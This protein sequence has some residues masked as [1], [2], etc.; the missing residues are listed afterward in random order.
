M[1]TQSGY[2]S[3][4]ANDPDD[5]QQ[6]QQGEQQPPTL[7]NRIKQF[8]YETYARKH[9]LPVV[10]LSAIV[11]FILLLVGLATWL[12]DVKHKN[13]AHPIEAPITP[14]ISSS[15]FRQGLAKCQQIRLNSKTPST[16]PQKRTS[17]PRAPQDSQPVVLRNAVVWDG[18]GKIL[19]HVDILMSNGVISQVK[20]NIQAPASAKIIDVGG[21]IVSPGIVDM[22]T[23]VDMEKGHIA[24]R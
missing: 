9:H 10:A 5:A 11:L 15:A 8:G 6:A 4:P 7:L 17:N 3:I 21:H 1:S 13:T 16:D 12:P 19:N 23:Y 22:H 20:Q 14:G 18:Q 24:K 2:R